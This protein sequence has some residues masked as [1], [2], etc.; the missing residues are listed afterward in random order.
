MSQP[1]K[2][3]LFHH[4]LKATISVDRLFCLSVDSFKMIHYCYAVLVC[5]RVKQ[6]FQGSFNQ[7]ITAPPL[8]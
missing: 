2:I 3:Y 1:G 8:T 5:A 6:E 4:G 7:G